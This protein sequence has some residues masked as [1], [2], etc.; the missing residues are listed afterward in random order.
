MSEPDP[1]VPAQATKPKRR[2]KRRTKIVYLTRRVVTRRVVTSGESLILVG[3]GV[4]FL[5]FCAAS[6]MSPS[7]MLPPPNPPSDPPVRGRTMLDDLIDFLVRLR[8][9]IRKAPTPPAG[10]ATTD[11]EATVDEADA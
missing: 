9:D 2:R 5:G 4:L 6:A 10:P 8:R 3:L 1:V 11:G 7:R